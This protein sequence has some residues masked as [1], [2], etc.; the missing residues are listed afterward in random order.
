MITKSVTT[1]QHLIISPKM[2]ANS[3]LLLKVPKWPE[4]DFEKIHRGPING[5]VIHAPPAHNDRCGH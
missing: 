5:N 2:S 1:M 3:N 4:D